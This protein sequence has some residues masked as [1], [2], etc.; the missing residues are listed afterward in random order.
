M[1]KA[2]WEPDAKDRLIIFLWDEY[3]YSHVTTGED[4]FRAPETGKN[5][6]YEL[7]PEEANLP[8]VA[9]E[10]F[11]LFGE[12]PDLSRQAEWS[13]ITRLLTMELKARGISGYLIRTPSFAPV[14][15]FERKTFASKTAD[16]LAAAIAANSDSQEFSEAGYVFRKLLGD[17]QVVFSNISGVQQL[18][19]YDSAFQALEELLPT[20]NR[21]LHEGG[22]I[23]E[24]EPVV[25]VAAER[26]DCGRNRQRLRHPHPRQP[27]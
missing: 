20:K 16:M 25:G 1:A 12:L 3:D 22:Y 2:Q 10:I 15:K 13:Q 7:S 23:D 11:R 24:H 14:K 9:L 19:S 18:R 8:T 4:V 26:M 27:G 21:Q 17:S 6:D 5:Y